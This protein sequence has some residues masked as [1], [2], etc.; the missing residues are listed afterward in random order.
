MMEPTQVMD[1]G[2]MCVGID[3]T[4]AV[5]GAWQAGSHTGAQKVNEPG[6]VC[7]NEL[8]TRDGKAADAF[9][10][11]VFG[12]QPEQVGD[13]ETFDYTV[14]KV[15]EGDK[16]TQVCGRL[17]MTAEWP[18]EIPAHWMTYFAVDDCDKAAERVA[19]LGGKVQQAPFDSPYGRVAVVADPWGA[20]FSLMQ[21]AD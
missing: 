20:T 18:A 5:F 7:W 2:R 3:P 4:G 17:Q 11:A 16:A 8:N 21:L 10:S 13:G 19:E 9:Y 1:A 15:G 14:W 12:D 6:A